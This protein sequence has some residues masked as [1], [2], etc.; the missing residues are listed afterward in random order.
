MEFVYVMKRRRHKAA[1]SVG[2]LL[3]AGG[4]KLLQKT[5]ETGS[6]QHEI[7]R[8]LCGR[9]VCASVALFPGCAHSS[10]ILADF[11]ERRL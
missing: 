11:A 5:D 7:V 8:K 10:N 9:Y 3:Y 6:K 2:L 4:R 1:S